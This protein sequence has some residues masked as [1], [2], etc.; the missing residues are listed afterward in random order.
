MAW[1]VTAAWA[2]TGVADIAVDASGAHL[3]GLRIDGGRARPLPPGPVSFDG[4]S[5]SFGWPDPRVHSVIGGATGKSDWGIAR[6]RFPWPTGA[7]GL[8][9]GTELRIPILAGPTTAI[10]LHGEGA[11]EERLD[12]V[13]LADGYRTEDLAKFEVDA[14]LVVDHLLTL[15]PWA[16]YQ[17]LLGIWRVNTES[18]ESGVDHDE[19]PEPLRR[20]TALG[21]AYGCDGISRLLCCDDALVLN[22]A[23]E[24]LPAVDGILVLVNDLA[25]GGAGGFTYAAAY[26][27]D[28]DAVLVAAHEIG[29]TLV[30]L[31]DEYSYGVTGPGEGPNCAPAETV[32]WDEWL[33]AE[34]V[35]TFSDCSFTNLSRPTESGCIMKTLT[36]GYCPVCRQE[37]MFALYDKVPSL[38]TSS[39]PPMGSALSP[40]D[41]VIPNPVGIVGRLEFEWT[42]GD[43]VV[44][45][46]D[47]Y[48]VS[49]DDPG[50]LLGLVARDPTA[51]VRDDPYGLT[52]QAV[53]AWPIDRSSCPGQCGCEHFAVG[54]LPTL[55]VPW[56][57][58]RRRK[59]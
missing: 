36:D 26:T 6:V 45:T 22:A 38:V 14:Q 56:F 46:D 25:Y 5:G 32:P 7:R 18:V 16:T 17:D 59:C 53:G 41:E 50:D 3:V 4:A 13:I 31:W 2:A 58:R 20:D 52:A 29:H 57:F 9:L 40:G 47:T 23:D 55:L 12:L 35:D 33:G 51:W 39:N 24:A 21:C 43:E 48:T 44:G 30:G 10:R 8:R 11:A 34:G 15:E 42:V 19:W 49:C 54:K 28:E 27:G 37:A 1:W